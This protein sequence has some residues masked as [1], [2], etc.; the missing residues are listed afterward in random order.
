MDNQL[1]RSHAGLSKGDKSTLKM[2][3]ENLILNWRLDYHTIQ[4]R[5]M[6]LFNHD[7]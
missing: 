1:T 4:R 2:I 3:F 7:R 5:H 6:K